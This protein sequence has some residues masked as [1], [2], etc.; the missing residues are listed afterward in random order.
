MRLFTDS[1]RWGWVLGASELKIRSKLIPDRVQNSGYDED[2]IE[3][4]EGLLRE[5]GP[6]PRV[7][8]KRE[9]SDTNRSTSQ[10]Q[11]N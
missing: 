10:T 6:V 5:T 4:V 7:L 3:G 11:S 9:D 8:D 1:G 2:V